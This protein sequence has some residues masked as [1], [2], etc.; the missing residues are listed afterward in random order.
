MAGHIIS[1]ERLGLRRWLE[2]DILPF[3]EMNG[4]AAVMQHFPKTLTQTETVETVQRINRH[5]DMHG[6]GLYAVE[7]KMSGEFIGFTG[8]MIPRF[9]S[10]FTPC[11]EIGWRFK[12]EKW[13]HGFASEAAKACLHHGFTALQFKKIVSFTSAINL[14]SEKVMQRIGMV[15]VGEFDHTNIDAENVLCKH[16][17]YEI[18]NTE[19]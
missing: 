15:K 14:K 18:A 4:D 10:F 17:L 1:T 9:E 7:D 8:F 19:N 11:I 16:V 13:G 12:K 6:F 5:F 3:T 2:T